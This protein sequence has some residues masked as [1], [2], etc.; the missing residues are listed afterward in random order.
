VCLVVNAAFTR[1]M[2]STAGWQAI[3]L[4]AA[5]SSSVAVAA[6]FHASVE[7]PLLRLLVRTR[8]APST[9]A[10]PVA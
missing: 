10:P 5:I 7:V 6:A 2:P 1:F 3:G 9:H 4:F 8:S